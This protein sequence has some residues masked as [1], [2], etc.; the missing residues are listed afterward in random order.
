M[1]KTSKEYQVLKLGINSI[2]ELRVLEKKMGAAIHAF[3][4]EFN[5]S[6][7]SLGKIETAIIDIL[8]EMFDDKGPNSWISYY[9]YDCDFG[10]NAMQVTLGDRKITMKTIANLW[11]VLKH[12]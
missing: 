2:K 1:S 5:D 10:S 4:P 8:K 9:I 3:D 6:H 12:Y 11:D 7:F